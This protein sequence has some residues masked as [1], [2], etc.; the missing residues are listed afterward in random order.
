MWSGS[1]RCCTT[2][3]W[4]AAATSESEEGTPPPFRSLH[5]PRSRPGVPSGPS[6]FSH[7][8]P[9][10][11]KPKCAWVII[12]I[13]SSLRFRR[14]RFVVYA[15]DHSPRHV[16]GF[17]EGAQV[18]IDLLRNGTVAVAKRENAAKP[19]S[20]KRSTVR[21]IL[22]EAAAHFDEL[23]SLWEEFHGDKA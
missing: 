16:H 1:I 2:T 3:S 20:A 11:F 14:V 4:A 13:V 6:P 17:L 7:R 8:C 22:N 15:N 21:K 12:G 19:G 10:G 9:F 23:V 18:V 5:L